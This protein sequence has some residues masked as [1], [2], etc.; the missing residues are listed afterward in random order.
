MKKQ[1]IEYY[2]LEKLLH[3][4]RMSSHKDWNPNLPK[5]SV[6]KLGRATTRDSLE[7]A[8]SKFGS[9]KNTWVSNPVGLGFVQFGNLLHA[10]NA[11]QV[12]DGQ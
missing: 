4:F 3:L 10:K 7:L 9:V 2:N 6:G 12:M 8:F 1:S 5:I 11:V